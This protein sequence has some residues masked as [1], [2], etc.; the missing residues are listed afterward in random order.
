MLV[1]FSLMLLKLI[2]N[3]TLILRSMN[4]IKWIKVG[5]T[6]AKYFITLILGALGGAEVAND[7][8]SNLLNF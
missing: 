1:C 3:S 2:H 6:V 4:K 8:V 5:L 7:S